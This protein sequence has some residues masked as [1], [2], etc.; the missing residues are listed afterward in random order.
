MVQRM[1]SIVPANLYREV[2]KCFFDALYLVRLVALGHGRRSEE[3]PAPYTRRGAV[4]AE[5]MLAFVEDCRR[6]VRWNPIPVC[7]VC[8]LYILDSILG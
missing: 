7:V 5:A 1:G 3:P 6:E 8:S 4:Q 2:M